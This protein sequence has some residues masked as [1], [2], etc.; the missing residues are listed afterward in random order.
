MHGYCITY[1]ARDTYITISLLFIVSLCVFMCVSLHVCVHACVHVCVICVCCVCAYVR[2]CMWLSE[3]VYVRACVLLFLQ[4]PTHPAYN[5][6]LEK[7]QDTLGY[8]SKLSLPTIIS[9]TD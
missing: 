1:V 9:S 5:I 8:F 4:R 2:M 3:C 6:G 7:V